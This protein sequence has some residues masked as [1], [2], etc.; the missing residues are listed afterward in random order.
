M[1]YIIFLGVFVFGLFCLVRPDYFL[2][3]RNKKE[4]NEDAELD[5]RDVRFFRIFGAVLMAL[6]VGALVLDLALAT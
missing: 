2:K 1:I 5:P 3:R 4:Q 6:M